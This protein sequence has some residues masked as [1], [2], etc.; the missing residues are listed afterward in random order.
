MAKKIL[1]VSL[2]EDT[3]QYLEVEKQPA[4]FFLQSLPTVITQESLLAACRK[5]DEIYINGLF[6]TALYEWGTFPKVARRYLNNLVNQDARAKLG[7]PSPVQIQYETV[8][9]VVDAGIAKW[10][11]AYAAIEEDNIAFIWDTFKGY[12]RKIKFISPL[13]VALAST[14][15]QIDQPQENFLTVWVGETS[16]VISIS[17]PEGFVKVARSVPMGL[18]KKGL[19]DAPAYLSQ[20]SQDLGKEISMTLTFFKQQFREAVPGTLYLLGNTQL[21]NIF[22]NYPLS[23]LSFAIHYR[24]AKSPVE[25]MPENQVCENIHLIGNLYLTDIFNFLPRE[26]IITRKTHFAF[27]AAY[28]AL[29]LIIVLG[30]FWGL[31]LTNTKLERLREHNNTLS[32]LRNLQKQ[33]KVL[34]EDVGRLKPFEGWKELYENTFKNQPPWNMFFSELGLLIPSNILVKT[35]QV[36]PEKGPA[37]IVWTSQMSGQVKAKNWHEGLNLLRQFGG[38]LQSSP[39]FEVVNIQYAPEEMQTEAK[40]FDFQIAMQLVSEGS[41]HEI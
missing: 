8:K 6:P 18:P 21:Q 4:G 3:F 23:G 5:A 15:A 27:R 30:G 17:S 14:I 35:F 13:P 36:A 2:L 12:T 1:S 31:T 19:A 9:E 28:A 32:Q 10:Q 11:V 16:S 20:F 29:V 41:S 24:L 38:V 34:R 25:G 33:V 7:A 26:E 37:G 40:T 22:T 39:F